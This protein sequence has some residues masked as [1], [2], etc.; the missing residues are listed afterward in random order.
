MRQKEKEAPVGLR[1]R[2]GYTMESIDPDQFPEIREE[3][4]AQ[5]D[6]SER[7]VGDAQQ[8]DYYSLLNLPR[9][10]SDEDIRAAYKRL[11]VILHPDKHRDPEAKQRAEIRFTQLHEAYECLSDPEK[12]AV[13]DLYGV[14]G[15]EDMPEWRVGQKLKSKEEIRAEYERH[16]LKLK[17]QEIEQLAKTTAVSAVLF[18]MYHIILLYIL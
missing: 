11:S 15:L 14:G 3:P 6:D 13:Y 8:F 16:R 17:Q 9:T 1:Q 2:L 18:Y 7:D 10:A 12:R 4:S 5:E